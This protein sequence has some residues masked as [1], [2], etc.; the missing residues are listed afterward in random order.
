[1]VLTGMSHCSWPGFCMLFCMTQ[2]LFF[3]ASKS[4][5]KTSLNISS[6]FS[7]IK[8]FVKSRAGFISFY[9]ALGN[10]I[11]LQICF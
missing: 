3:S 2:S 6:H 4:K 8:I 9:N 1:K 7:F 10:T 5:F 11:L